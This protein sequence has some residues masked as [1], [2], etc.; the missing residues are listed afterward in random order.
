M[1]S[2]RNDLTCTALWDLVKIVD[3]KKSLN[4]SKRGKNSRKNFVQV[5]YLSMTSSVCGYYDNTQLSP[6]EIVSFGK[7]ELSF[8]YLY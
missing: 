8:W 6:N 3:T 2:F 7:N 4:I 5:H 1:T